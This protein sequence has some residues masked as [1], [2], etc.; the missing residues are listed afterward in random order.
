MPLNVSAIGEMMSMS[1][2]TP[3]HLFL[4]GLLD[5]LVEGDE[6]VTNF[7]VALL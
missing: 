1:A 3:K 2:L 6:Q 7:V 4:I 5:N